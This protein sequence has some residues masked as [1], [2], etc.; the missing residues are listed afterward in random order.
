MFF[1][2]CDFSFQL[3]RQR[4]LVLEHILGDKVF[5]H[6]L[7]DDFE[8]LENDLL[9]HGAHSLPLT[10]HHLKNIHEEEQFKIFEIHLLPSCH[11]FLN[12]VNE[13]S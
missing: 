8:V 11:S 1:H 9:V 2:P 3:Q 5:T 12:G 10:C 13:F 4:D 7:K 6:A